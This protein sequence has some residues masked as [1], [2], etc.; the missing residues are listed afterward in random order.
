MMLE[1]VMFNVI[2]KKKEEMLVVSE[3]QVGMEKELIPSLLRT[4]L[5]FLK[6][7]FCCFQ[8]LS[9]PSP[10]VVFIMK[11]KLSWEDERN[12]CRRLDGADELYILNR[13]AMSRDPDANDD[14]CKTSKMTIT[15]AFSTAFVG[16]K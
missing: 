4:F 6:H 7:L 5:W 2:I 3:T 1:N 12:K 8:L 13:R 9:F 16:K 11:V 10:V 14:E 15:F